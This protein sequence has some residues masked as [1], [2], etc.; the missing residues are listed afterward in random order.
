MKILSQI[1]KAG[2]EIGP[3]SCEYKSVKY[4]YMYYITTIPNTGNRHGKPRLVE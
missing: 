3:F 2:S 1:L 4:T